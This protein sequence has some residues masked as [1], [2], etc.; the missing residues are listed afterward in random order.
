MQSWLDHRHIGIDITGVNTSDLSQQIDKMGATV[1]RDAVGLAPRVIEAIFDTVIVLV[2][3]CYM[4]LDA[5]RI[6]SAMINVTPE[7]Y[8]RDVRV[9][10][11]S[12]DH[13]FGGYIRA[14]VLLALLYGAGT[15]LTM[16]TTG[17]PFILPVS[18]FAG[19]MLIIPFI[20]DVVAVIPP[21][22]IGLVT[23]SV[24]RVSIALVVL[25]ALQQL[26]LQVI[27][28]KLMGKSV[29]LHPLWVLAAFFVGAGAAGVWG[30]LFSVPIAA[31]V[32]SVVQLYYYRMTGKPP[33]PAL[34][35]L[36]VS[37]AG[38]ASPSEMR[39]TGG[40]DGPAEPADTAPEPARPLVG[41]KERGRE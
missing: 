15:G 28:P 1:T 5:P 9:L 26:V 13:S 6:T 3:S 19:F 25:I 22:L 41:A 18:M 11:A 17:I 33:P 35:A 20:G 8:R 12:V 30:A 38:S 37:A 40:P 23:V 31:I 32:Q 2:I 14:S 34:R 10:F 29:G 36:A 21:I 27:R 24:L 16:W 39:T 7:R 4:M